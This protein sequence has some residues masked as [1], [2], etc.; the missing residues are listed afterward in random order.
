MA[1]LIHWPLGP[2][3][4]PASLADRIAQERLSTAGL[5]PQLKFLCFA[6]FLQGI[7]CILRMKHTQPKLTRPDKSI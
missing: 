2:N 7:I 1:A 3:C 4:P 6:S 5:R